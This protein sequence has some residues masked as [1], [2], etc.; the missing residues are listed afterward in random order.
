MS[1][2]DLRHNLCFHSPLR[3]A[4]LPPLI[5]FNRTFAV[6]EQKGPETGR[7]GPEARSKPRR[8]PGIRRG[9]AVF[10]GCFRLCNSC[11]IL[12]RGH[13]FPPPIRFGIVKELGKPRPHWKR[14]QGDPRGRGE[15]LG[16]LAAGFGKGTVVGRVPGRSPN[17]TIHCQAL[18][19]GN[20]QIHANPEEQC[21]PHVSTPNARIPRVPGC[22][23]ARGFPDRLNGVKIANRRRGPSLFYRRTARGPGAVQARAGVSRGIHVSSIRIFGLGKCFWSFVGVVLCRS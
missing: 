7:R 15:I 18:R 2:Q 16:F 14:L 5:V 20:D 3:I 19:A 17:D 11:V 9:T 10:P 22:R 8:D 12:C 23:S 21:P 4:I 6:K 1:P 13:F